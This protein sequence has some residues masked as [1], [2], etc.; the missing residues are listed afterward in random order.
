MCDYANGIESECVC[1]MEF[2]SGFVA[3]RL[4]LKN[5]QGRKYSTYSSSVPYIDVED[6]ERCIFYL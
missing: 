2:D 1:N 3:F 6:W 5:S 4:G